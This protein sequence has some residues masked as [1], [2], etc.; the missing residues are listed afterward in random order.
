MKSYFYKPQSDS[1]SSFLKF[2]S[3]RSWQNLSVKIIW[4]DAE[5]EIVSPL[6]IELIET[7]NIAYIF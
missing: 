6:V 3:S 5:E 7:L 2:S 4:L 1:E